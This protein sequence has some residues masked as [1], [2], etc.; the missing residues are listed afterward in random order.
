M[1]IVLHSAVNFNNFN[2][3]NL[4]ACAGNT[5]PAKFWIKVKD[6]KEKKIAKKIARCCL[7]AEDPQLWSLTAEDPDLF[8]HT[9]RT[10]AAL[11]DCLIKR[12]KSFC[13]SVV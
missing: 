12:C 8:L 1:M 9:C 3:N 13:F 10:T 6:K 7:Y 4:S 11:H 5:T 2:N